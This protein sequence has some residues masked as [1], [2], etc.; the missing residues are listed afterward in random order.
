MKQY[1]S[2]ELK[3]GIIKLWKINNKLLAN[4]HTFVITHPAWFYDIIMIDKSIINNPFNK[5][6]Q[7]IDLINRINKQLF[8]IIIINFF[9]KIKSFLN[10]KL[11]L[12]KYMFISYY[13]KFKNSAI[14]LKTSLK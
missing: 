13:Y 1:E 8:N 11:I 5:I 12:D 3:A 10:Y 14:R 7:L 4:L 6:E 2:K 9:A